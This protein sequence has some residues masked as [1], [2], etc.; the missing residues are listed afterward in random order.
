MLA[1]LQL[2]CYLANWP[3]PL[4]FS[5]LL[6]FCASVPVLLCSTHGACL[7][8]A[9]ANFPDCT[10]EWMCSLCCLSWMCACVHSSLSVTVVTA[11]ESC[12][13]IFDIII[14]STRSYSECAVSLITIL[15]LLFPCRCPRPRSL[16][17][18]RR[19]KHLLICSK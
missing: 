9:A 7:L 13:A 16:L 1:L 17:V 12:C 2:F 5:S 6:C 8:F 14:E 18:F 19:T 15:A 11:N 3:R 10:A 4:F